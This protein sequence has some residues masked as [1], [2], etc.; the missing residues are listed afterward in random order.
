MNS[1]SLDANDGLYMGELNANGEAY[2]EGFVTFPDCCYYKGTWKNGM[3][4]GFGN[5]YDFF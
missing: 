1:E 2:G 4:H 5:F 3:V